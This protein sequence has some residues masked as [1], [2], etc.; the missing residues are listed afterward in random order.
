MDGLGAVAAAGA[1]AGVRWTRFPLSPWPDDTWSPA[2]VNVALN[3][4]LDGRLVPG[5]PPRVDRTHVVALDGVV[6][7]SL[8][9]SLLASLL[10]PDAHETDPT[11]PDTLWERA[12]ADAVGAAASWG[13]RDG[14]LAALM[15]AP[16]ASPAGVLGGR[17]A[18]LFPSCDVLLLPSRD[19]GGESDGSVFSPLLANAPVHGDTFSWH[20]DADPSSTPASTPWAAAYGRYVNGDAGR[21]RLV[22]LVVHLCSEWSADWQ[23]E[24]L[25][26]DA[27]A[28]VGAIVAP[29]PGRIVLFDGDVMHRL[30]SP[31]PTAGRPRYSLAWRLALAPRSPGAAPPS[32]AALATALGA[33]PPGDL[34]SAAA[35]GAL[36]RR[37]AAERKAAA[38]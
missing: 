13:L 7:D 29:A 30:V 33:G 5:A 23:G 6:D 8:R 22:T 26:R 12:T 21:P 16:H 35:L 34:G 18:S 3:V 4:R 36:V 25:F 28:G 32:P 20:T 11:P 24:T 38:G 15:H 31:C 1:S 10:G 17:L 9:A 37:V 14:P 19:M 2:A 27:T